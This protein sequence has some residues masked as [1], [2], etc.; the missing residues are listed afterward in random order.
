MLT[1]NALADCHLCPRGCGVN[2]LRGERGYCAAVGA[3]VDVARAGLHRGEEPCL[4]LAGAVFFAH[5]N[6]RCVYCQNYAVSHE[7]CGR[8]VGLERLAQ[9]FLE[10]QHSGADTL[11]LV[12]PTHYA[13]QIIAALRL[14]RQRGLS[15]P[16]VW[17]CGGYESLDTIAAI[18]DDVDVFLPDLKYHDAA[19]SQRYSGAADY[20]ARATAAITAMVD[21]NGAADFDD[22]GIMRRGVLVRHLVLPG[23]RR[24]SLRLVEWFAKNVAGRAWLSLMRQ[25]T[26]LGAL[27]RFPELRRPLTTFEYESVVERAR[28]LGI[29]HGFRQKREAVGE[30]FVPRFDGSGV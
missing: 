21:G 29:E 13:P 15:L 9:I 11:D 4:G 30:G 26:P 5:C 16:V 6:L 27:E 24:D 20:F 12:T 22:K 14:A 25:Y 8:S 2:R 19:L 23:Q 18:A 10:Q 3:H 28:Q 17:N 7:G 1:P